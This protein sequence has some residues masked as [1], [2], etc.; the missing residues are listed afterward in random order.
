M[1]IPFVA[2]Y[3]DYN[4]DKYNEAITSFLFSVYNPTNHNYSDEPPNHPHPLGEP[5]VPGPPVW[6]VP[7]P[8]SMTRPTCQHPL[9]PLPPPLIPSLLLKGSLNLPRS[10]SLCKFK[11]VTEIFSDVSVQPTRG[12]KGK[13]GKDEERLEGEESVVSRTSTLEFV[14][15]K[16]FRGMRGGISLEERGGI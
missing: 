13:F 5:S 16:I 6:L 4:M 11:E 14:F 9:V 7:A 2:F 1:G 15:E 3:M 12:G 8:F 10:Y